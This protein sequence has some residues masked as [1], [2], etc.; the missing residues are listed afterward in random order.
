MVVCCVAAID[1]VLEETA[2]IGKPEHYLLNNKIFPGN[3]SEE[4][5]DKVQW[6]R[7]VKLVIDV[8]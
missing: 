5:K 6:N 7:V 1:E 2:E 8:V 3:K 4:V